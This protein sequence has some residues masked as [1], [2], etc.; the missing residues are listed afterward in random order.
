MGLCLDGSVCADVLE[1]APRCFR[2]P[3]ETLHFLSENHRVQMSIMRSVLPRSKLVGA[4]GRAR[5]AREC[6]PMG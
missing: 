6:L 2:S 1:K 4:V 5:G 3:E